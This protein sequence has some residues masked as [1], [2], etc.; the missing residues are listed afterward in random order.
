MSIL[1]IIKFGELL[2]W[3]SNWTANKIEE[4]FDEAIKGL[5]KRD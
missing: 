3:S 4:G 2:V 1:T 5:H